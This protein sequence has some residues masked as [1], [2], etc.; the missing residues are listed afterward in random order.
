MSIRHL[1][2]LPVLASLACDDG[3]APPPSDSEFRD[4]YICF[5]KDTTP[6]TTI[7][8]KGFPP[9]DG[10]DP[11]PHIRSMV[12][13]N[14]DSFLA[15]SAAWDPQNGKACTEV[16]TDEKMRWKGENCVAERGYRFGE[17]EW[18]T[19]ERG[20]KTYRVVVDTGTTVIGCACAY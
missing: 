7:L 13:D 14:V 15:A 16:C 2:L 4:G 5:G 19:D 8:N 1:L 9:D 17:T 3:S 18:G 20:S 12:A 6:P 10:P 11:G